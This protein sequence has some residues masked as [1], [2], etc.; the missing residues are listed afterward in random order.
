MEWDAFLWESF[1]GSLDII[2]KLAFIIFP[3]FIFIEIIDEI[4]LLEKISNLFHGVLKYFNLPKEAGLPILIAQ[5]FGL[6]FGAGLIIRSTREDELKEGDMMSLAILFAICHAVFEDTLLFVAIGGNGFIIL[7][8][9][10]IL[11]LIAT[12]LYGK[13]RNYKNEYTDVAKSNI[14]AN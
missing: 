14:S 2:K 3:L 5:T 8:T 9:R 12:Y 7:G 6:L 1:I 13:F 11:A 10:I 4:G